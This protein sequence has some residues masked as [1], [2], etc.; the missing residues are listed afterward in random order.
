MFVL[1][2]TSMNEIIQWQNHTPKRVDHELSSQQALY[3]KFLAM[4]EKEGD[5]LE[6]QDIHEELNELLETIRKLTSVCCQNRESIIF[7]EVD[8]TEKI[9]RAL[10][11]P[12]LA[13]TSKEAVISSS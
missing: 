11:L 2:Y 1:V 7:W 4:Y 13:E 12:P 5:P 8:Y 6:K 10:Y 9:R 3:S